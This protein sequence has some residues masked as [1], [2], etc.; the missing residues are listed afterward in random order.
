[1]HR[2]MEY[3]VLDREY[4]PCSFRDQRTTT[5]LNYTVTNLQIVVNSE[6][7]SLPVMGLDELTLPFA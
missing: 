5:K 1:M 4:H 2:A 6:K 3:R 7:W